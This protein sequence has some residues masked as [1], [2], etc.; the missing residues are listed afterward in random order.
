MKIT[1]ITFEDHGQ[2]FLEWDINEVGDILDCRPFQAHFWKQCMVANEDQLVVGGNV[3]F[4]S[5]S[6]E[7]KAIKYPIKSLSVKNVHHVS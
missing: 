7:V 6:C 3:Y 5:R 2:D 1:T 4:L